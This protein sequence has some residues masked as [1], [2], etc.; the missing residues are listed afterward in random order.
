[1]IRASRFAVNCGSGEYDYYVAKD[2]TLFFPDHPWDGVYGSV[3]DGSQIG[4]AIQNIEGTDDPELY[5]TEAYNLDA[6]R[7]KVRNGAYTVRVYLKIGYEPNA[8]EGR[9]VFTLTVN[10]RRF[11]DNFDLFRET[12]SFNRAIVREM[13]GIEVTDGMLTLDFTVPDGVHPSV[14]FLNAIEVIPE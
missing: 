14:R 2:G 7:F 11:L 10:G 9:G 1:M 12:G 5:A 8:K 3:S 13:K 6:Y 4:R